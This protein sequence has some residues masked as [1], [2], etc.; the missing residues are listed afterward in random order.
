MKVLSLVIPSYNS[1][2]YLEKC[3][4]SLLAPEI[5]DKLDIIIVNDGSTDRTAD[6]A[7]KYCTMYPDSVRLIS[8]SNKGHGGALNAGF[9][10]AAGKYLKAIDADDYVENLPQ[11]VRLLE[12]CESDVVLTHYHT[13][14]ITT[15]VIENWKSFPKKFGRSYTLDEIMTDWKR[16]DRSLTFHGIAYKT[17]F[18]HQHGI[19]LSEHVF[20]EDHE[21]AVIPCCYAKEVTPFDLFLYDYRVGDIQQSVSNVN[22]LRRISHT[23]AVLKRLFQEYDSLACGS[24]GKSYA[25]MKIQGLLLSYL[26]TVLL[27]EPDK[28]R[29]RRLAEARM[30]ECKA[31][32]PGAYALVYR[33]Y[34]VLRVMNRLH[35]SK[36]AWQSFLHSR[37]YNALRGN[38]GFDE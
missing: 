13:V 37:V 3:I 32:A 14:N 31:G 6:V 34:Q 27:A 38:R 19:R 26:T 30:A 33:K 1:E 15:G 21:Y 36:E 28:K 25:T 5:L 24:S 8:Q 29:G 7:E 10:L 18:Y 4:L 16:F 22:Q 35:I 17:T 11:F 9:A 20:Y 12:T 2:Q 23:E